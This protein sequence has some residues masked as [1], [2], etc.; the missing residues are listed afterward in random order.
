MQSQVF[1]DSYSQADDMS[2]AS[3]LNDPLTGNGSKLLTEDA[4]FGRSFYT[5]NP[6]DG[7]SI[8]SNL[9]DSD[10]MDGQLTTDAGDKRFSLVY[11]RENDSV[12]SINGDGKDRVKYQGNDQ[13]KD[14]KE[15]SYYIRLDSIIGRMLYSIMDFILFPE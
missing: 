4:A 13:C 1:S 9:F 11:S 2:Y 12:V 10:S 3:S 14:G 6:S 8:D 7:S 5:G 15:H